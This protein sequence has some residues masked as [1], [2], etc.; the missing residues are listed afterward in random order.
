MT[1]EEQKN[2]LQ[3]KWQ[4]EFQSEIEVKLHCGDFLHKL[5]HRHLYTQVFVVEGPTPTISTFYEKFS[6]QPTDNLTQISTFCEKAVQ[7]YVDIKNNG[8]QLSLF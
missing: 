4:E 5:T 3:Q 1:I 6:I 7:V 2:M 8:Q